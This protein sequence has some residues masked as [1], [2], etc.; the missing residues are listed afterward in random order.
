MRIPNDQAWENVC[1]E[2]DEPQTKRLQV[3]GGWIYRYNT[4]GD[5]GNLAMG[6]VFVPKP[7]VA[8]K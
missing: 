6:M 2:R 4:W 7:P 8:R 5:A 3:P 1:G